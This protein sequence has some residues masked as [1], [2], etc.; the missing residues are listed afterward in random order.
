MRH[1][2]PQGTTEKIVSP[3]GLANA[4][5]QRPISWETG[6]LT[7]NTIHVGSN[8]GVRTVVEYRPPQRT[9]IWLDDNPEP[10][11]VPMPGLLLVRKSSGE[12]H[13][14]YQIFAVKKR[15]S[16]LK[17]KLYVSPLPNTYRNGGICWGNVARLESS[18][19]DDVSLKADWSFL[20][21]S[22]FNNHSVNGKSVKY[23]GDIRKLL[24]ELDQQKT[25]KYPL[26]DLVSASL[27]LEAVL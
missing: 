23:S 16:N 7:P 27:A 22:G 14:D 17:T 24:I 10:L 15:P 19:L 20:L 5:A 2:T 8:A 9:G 6:I 12:G 3:E 13:P 18:V 25:E 21:G 1:T 11:R 4:M 26:D